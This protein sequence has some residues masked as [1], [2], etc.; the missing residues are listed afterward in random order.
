MDE[1]TTGLDITASFDY[2]HRIRRLA[3]DGR[4]IIIVTHHLNEIPPEVDRVILLKNGAVAAD[5]RKREV[6][7][8]ETLSDVYDTP[9]RVAEVDGYFL[10]YPW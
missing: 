9:V 5:G 6:L 7:T 2:L 1:P 4:N 3:R 8:A 10:A